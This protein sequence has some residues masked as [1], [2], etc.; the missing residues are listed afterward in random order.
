MNN[1]FLGTGWGFPPT[2]R[3]GT[4]TVDMVSDEQDVQQSLEILLTTGVGER[5]MQYRYGCNM[6]RLLFEPLNTT[7]QTY[8]E[9]IVKTAI[10]YF[11]PR[12]VL[13]S[14][15]L[16]PMSNEGRV[17]IKVEYTIAGTNSRYNYVYP[18]YKEEGNF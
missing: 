15:K 8:M 16:I 4:Q 5:V 12:I 10:L 2:F 1:S 9:D 14:V 18:F 6:T 7:L 3:K 11:E 17:D 13:N